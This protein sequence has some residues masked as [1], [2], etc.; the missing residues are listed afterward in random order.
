MLPHFCGKDDES[1]TEFINQLISTLQSHHLPEDSWKILMKGQL[2]LG[3]NST[4]SDS[5]KFMNEL[6][7]QHFDSSSVRTKLQAQFYGHTQTIPE[8]FPTNTDQ[9]AIEAIF[10]LLYANKYLH[11]SLLKSLLSGTQCPS[12]LNDA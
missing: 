4:P 8:K 9:S 10:L 3:L 6:F 5:L 2:Q 1:P 11:P 7:L 12:I